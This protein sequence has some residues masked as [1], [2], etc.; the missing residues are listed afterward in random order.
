MKTKLLTICLLLITLLSGCETIH[1]WDMRDL[2]TLIPVEE[3][4]EYII[5]RFQSYADGIQPV[6]SE[7]AEHRRITDLERRLKINGHDIMKYEIL[8][9][10]TVL[11]HR[12][13]YDIFL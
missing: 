5:Y 2:N 3:T 7:K 10:Q 13:V 11:K 8:K 12:S 9:R 4:S 1:K 6:D